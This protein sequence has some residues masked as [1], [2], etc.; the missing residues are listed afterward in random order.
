MNGGEKNMPGGDR[1]GP[2]GRGPMTGRAIGYCAGFSHPG[3]SNFGN[4]RGIGR[5]LG[6]GFGRGFLGRRM[7]WR[8]Y[9]PIYQEDFPPLSKDDQKSYLEN[10]V[11]DLE[12]EL[13]DIR[14]RIK[15]LSEKK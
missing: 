12:E 14:E 1:T 5:G 9:N 15:Q 11:K 2:L 10:L 3:Y 8:G 4:A 6:R 7:F 13:K